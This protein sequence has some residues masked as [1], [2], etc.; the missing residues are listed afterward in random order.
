MHRLHHTIDRE[1]PYNNYN[2]GSLLTV[3]DKA[4]RTYKPAG[5]LQEQSQQTFGVD[6]PYDRANN[7]STA[8]P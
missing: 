2:F 4:M 7:P 8:I 1:D 6:A 3:W 5:T